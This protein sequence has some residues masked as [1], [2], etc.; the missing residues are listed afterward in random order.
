M[1]ALLFSRVVSWC[2]KH[3]HDLS[4]AALTGFMLGALRAVWP[5]WVYETAPHPL[6][7]DQGMVLVPMD[8]VMPDVT[9]W[10]FLLAVVCAVGGF[11]VVIA[12]EYVAGVYQTRKGRNA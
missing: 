11:L 2:L 4:I 10:V 7:P 1:G 5:F 6:K 3:Y 9:S 12:M 8:M